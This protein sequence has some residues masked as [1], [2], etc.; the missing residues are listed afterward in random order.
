MK[1]NKKSLRKPSSLNKTSS[2]LEKPWVEKIKEGFT[3]LTAIISFIAAALGLLVFYANN[4]GAFSELK[5]DFSTWI[6]KRDAW[7][8][9]FNNFPE[10]H[11]DMASMNLSESDLQLVILVNGG[12]IDGVIA[13]KKLCKIGFPNG[14]KL[15]KGDI[16]FLGNTADVQAFDFEQGHLREYA[17]L[18]I[19]REGVI[20]EVTAKKGSEWLLPQPVR[21]AQHPTKNTD[22]GMKDLLKFCDEERAELMNLILKNRDAPAITS[23]GKK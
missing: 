16:E 2:T 4:K 15:L 10:G 23:E 18:E 21:I 20:L 22:T 6:Y 12:L 8:G 9:L 19:K 5:D 7:T 17:R 11:I 13:D 1:I 3:A 14:Y